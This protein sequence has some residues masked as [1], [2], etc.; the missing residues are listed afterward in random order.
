MF[1]AYERLGVAQPLE[2]VIV[3]HVGYHELVAHVSRTLVEKQ[4]LFEVV[5]RGIEVPVN[6]KLRGGAVENSDGGKV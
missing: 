2:T 4:T 3:A 6:R 5:D 1:V